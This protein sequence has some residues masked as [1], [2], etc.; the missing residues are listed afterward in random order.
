MPFFLAVA[1]LVATAYS[2]VKGLKGFRV[3]NFGFLFSDDNGE[4]VEG[5]ISAIADDFTKSA[6][7]TFEFLLTDGKRH[8]V[9][10]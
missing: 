8:S 2:L 5:N 4:N 6:V 10:N 3:N 7:Q 9:K 1:F